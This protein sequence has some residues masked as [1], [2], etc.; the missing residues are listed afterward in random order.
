MHNGFFL[1]SLEVNLRVK[2][3]VMGALNLHI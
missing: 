2:K 1:K 3:I